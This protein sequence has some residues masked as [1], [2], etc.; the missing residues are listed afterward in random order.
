[1][2]ILISI[3]S[4]L[5]LTSCAHTCDYKKACEYV[6]AY[7]EETMDTGQMDEFLESPY[8]KEYVKTIIK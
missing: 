8:G 1:M 7:I 6:N 2:R 3:C 4:I 5:L